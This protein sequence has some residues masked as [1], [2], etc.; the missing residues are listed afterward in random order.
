MRTNIQVTSDFLSDIFL[1]SRDLICSVYDCMKYSLLT[2]VNHALVDS[3]PS[4]LAMNST[5]NS[6]ASSRKVLNAAE[7]SGL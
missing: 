4:M 3:F 5:L 2:F 7:T 6:L 1:I